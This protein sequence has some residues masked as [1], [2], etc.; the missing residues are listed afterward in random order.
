M[1]RDIK[2]IVITSAVRTPIGTFRGSLKEMQAS[3]LGTLVTKAAIQKSN[4]TP[5]IIYRERSSDSEKHLDAAEQHR[6]VQQQKGRTKS[7]KG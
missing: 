3:D 1:H 7:R 5:I 4:S 6:P 2:N